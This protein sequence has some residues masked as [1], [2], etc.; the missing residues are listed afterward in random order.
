MSSTTDFS[1]V[2]FCEGVETGHSSHSEQASIAKSLGITAPSI[3]MDSQAK[4]ASISRGVGE[5][6]LRLPV[7][8]SYEEKIWVC[9]LSLSLFSLDSNVRRTMPQDH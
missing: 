4:Y 9:P 6:Y 1:K 3:R 7:S 5:I 8:L 2:R